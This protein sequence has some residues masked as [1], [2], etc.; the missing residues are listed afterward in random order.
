[1]TD[2]QSYGYMLRYSAW[3]VDDGFCPMSFYE[4]GMN[5]HLT[6]PVDGEKLLQVLYKY[7]KTGL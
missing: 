7:K 6:K 1:M 4:A 5:E 2:E 3:L